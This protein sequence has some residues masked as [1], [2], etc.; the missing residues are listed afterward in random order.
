MCDSFF[1][2]I[3]ALINA[4][5][6]DSSPQTGITITDPIFEQWIRRKMM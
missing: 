4:D 3:F 5:L 1:I 2:R 6:I